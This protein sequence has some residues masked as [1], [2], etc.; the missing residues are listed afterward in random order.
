MRA[1]GCAVLEVAPLRSA[2]CCLYVA[3]ARATHGGARERARRAVAKH[4]APRAA[5]A[6]AGARRTLGVS[7][8]RAGAWSL[9][10]P[11]APV[12]L[13]SRP[14][15][16]RAR[17]WSAARPS[18]W[19]E[20]AHSGPGPLARRGRSPARRATALRDRQ[21]A[22]ALRRGRAARASIALA[23]ARRCV[24][25][26]AVAPCRA[27]RCS[28]ASRSARGARAD[29]PRWAASATRG[30][31]CR[32]GSTRRAA[33][34]RACAWSLASVP[35]AS[36]AERCLERDSRVAAAL[37]ARPAIAGRPR[38]GARPAM[39]EL[40]LERG[41]RESSGA[42][43]AFA[44]GALRAR[45]SRATRTHVVL[46]RPVDAARACSPRSTRP[47]P[48]C[49]RFAFRARPG[50][51]HVRRRHARAA[52]RCADARS[53]SD[54]L[55]GS[56]RRDAG[57]DAPARA[58]AARER[59]GSARARARRR[60]DPRARCG[61][62]APRS[63]RRPRRGCARCATSTTSARRSRAT[64][65][66]AAH[67]LELVARAAPDAGGRRHAARGRARLDRA[68]TSRRRA[69]GTRRR[70]LVRRRAAT[71]SSRSRSAPALL[72]RPRGLAVRRR[73]HRRGLGSGAPSTPRRAS[74]RRRCSAA[75]G[76]DVAT[77]EV[78]LPAVGDRDRSV[79]MA[80]AGSSCAR[81]PR[82]R[83]RRRGQPRLAL[84]AARARR[85]GERRAARRTSSS[86]SAPR[87][88]SRSAR[89]A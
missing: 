70:R 3:E 36:D 15:R 31:C 46:A 56:T 45:S 68:R 78:A 59:Q 40:P 57:D 58:R 14:H 16:A 52:G 10:V 38:G 80:W 4:G 74:S 5:R 9:T 39:R 13:P 54:A 29:E 7:D 69:A 82:R 41:A 24:R 26:P 48:E 47:H 73:R 28:A 33:S 8:R 89:R 66:R 83:T 85:R 34:A 65:A 43:D 37:D 11:I 55:A 44:R 79:Q 35:S 50:R 2:C 61:R 75:L 20:P 23:R 84:D 72:A 42:R 27:P 19:A 71:A 77:L 22:R 25:R 30:S 1:A 60:R 32:A 17:A 12:R 87:R 49:V 64:L 88:S 6:L 76:L 62:S 67:V 81:S 51:A 63:T 21:R 18:L 86:T 53:H